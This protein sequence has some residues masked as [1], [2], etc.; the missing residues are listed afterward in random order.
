[1]HVRPT[2]ATSQRAS[3][4]YAIRQILCFHIPPTA[5]LNNKGSCLMLKS[6]A[7]TFHVR[8]CMLG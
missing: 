3:I 8:A 1:M 4:F 5:R 7:T 2:A 6:I